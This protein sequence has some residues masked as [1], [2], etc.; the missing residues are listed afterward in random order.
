CDSF[1]APITTRIPTLSLHDALPISPSLRVIDGTL[2]LKNVAES[3]SALQ[4]PSSTTVSEINTNLFLEWSEDQRF[5]DIE[6]FS[7][8]TGELAINKL[9]MTGQVYSD[10]EYLEFNSF[11]FKLGR[12]EISVNGRI[13]G[14][15]LDNPNFINQLATAR[16]NLDVESKEFYP[17]EFSET[18]PVIP[19]W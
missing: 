1:T 13:E 12:T 8:E 5:L 11:Y 10:Q 3:S 7:A 16:Y 15:D 6:S 17:D 2:H 9:S 4:L 19:G 18:I 14:V